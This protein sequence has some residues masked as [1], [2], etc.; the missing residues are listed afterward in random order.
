MHK[1][2]GLKPRLRPTTDIFMVCVGF[3]K[4]IA[5]VQEFYFQMFGFGYGFGFLEAK[6]Y[7]EVIMASGR[8]FFSSSIS[9]TSMLYDIEG[10]RL[11][12]P[13]L[14]ISKDVYW[15]ATGLTTNLSITFGCLH[16]GLCCEELTMANEAFD[17][18]DSTV[19]DYYCIFGYKL[20]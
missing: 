4:K 8:A 14:H 9:R 1:P 3:L 10:L 5:C 12:I 20:G 2:T 18:F 16:C 7:G 11:K 17:Y 15:T 19:D 13:L 6:H